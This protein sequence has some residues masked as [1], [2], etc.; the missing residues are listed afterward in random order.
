MRVS[1]GRPELADSGVAV[2]LRPPPSPSSWVPTSTAAPTTIATM[3]PISPRRRR[4]RLGG[5]G[6]GGGPSGRRRGGGGGVSQSWSEPA[7][8][9]VQRDAIDINLTRPASRRDK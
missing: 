8:R 5:S 6:G 7:G 4:L 1:A 9:S 3:P 2:W